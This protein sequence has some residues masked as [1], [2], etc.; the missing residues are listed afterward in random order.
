MILNNN[1]PT[2]Q[3]KTYCLVTKYSD[4]EK[5]QQLSLAAV[6][7]PLWRWNSLPAMRIG[8]LFL[9]WLF[10]S[11]HQSLSVFINLYQYLSVFISLYQSLSVF[12][13][14]YQSLSVFISICQ[15]LSIFISVYQSC[16]RIMLAISSTIGGRGLKVQKLSVHKLGHN[17]AKLIKITGPQVYRSWL[18]IIVYSNRGIC[19]K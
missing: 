11:F 4:M 15:S 8:W 7:R 14:L 13:G 3:L 9:L 12:I 2:I 19:I 16:I 18:C 6:L 17:S 10:I 5:A 1:L